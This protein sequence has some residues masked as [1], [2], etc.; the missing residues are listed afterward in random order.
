M[1]GCG[2]PSRVMRARTTCYGGTDLL[3]LE[4]N[5]LITR[6]DRTLNRM[7]HLGPEFSQLQTTATLGGAS[8][9]E[10]ERAFLQER[11]MFLFKTLF[12]LS[13]GF[14][15][16]TSLFVPILEGQP[17]L[18]S[19]ISPGYM[20]H[21]VAV[22]IAYGLWQTCR[23]GPRS[24]RLLRLL[25]SVGL[26]FALYLLK[27]DAYVD[28]DSH[29]LMLGSNAALISR[30]VIVPTTVRRTFWISLA[31][32][33]PDAFLLALM[34][35]KTADGYLVP[36]L[37]ALLW[38]AIAIIMA[39][40]VTKVIYGL[41]KQVRDARKLGQYTLLEMLGAGAMGDVYLASHA[42]MRRRTAIK[43]LRANADGGLARFETEVQLTSQLTHPNTI[44]IYDYGRTAE[45]LFYYVMEYLEGMDLERLMAAAG[46]QSPARVIHILRQVC[47]A[48]EEAHGLGLLHR[49]IK[50]A[51][52]FLCRRRGGPD[53]VK[54]LD[55]GLV[56]QLGASE[57]GGTGQA[58]VVV[59]TPHYLA[60]E[61][62]M[63]PTKV[64]GRADLYSLGA[65]AYALLTGGHVF[66]GQTASEICAH[67][68]NTP[69]E[70]PAARLGR[71]LPDDLCGVVLRCLE[72]RPESRFANA[73]ELRIALELCAD[74]GRWTEED[75]AYWWDQ[76]GVELEKT[77]VRRNPLTLTGTQTVVSNA[78]GR[79]AA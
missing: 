1:A 61:A 9:S 49:D 50:P 11:M 79:V 20:F 59:G 21:L 58:H 34:R 12:L 17:W 31:G 71:E 65:V 45:G 67:H 64:D 14:Y 23:G 24:A 72:K 22:V 43:L 66:Q 27:I 70:P 53:W 40:L 69:P 5:R 48:L 32:V 19:L 55:F 44:A 54:V 26:L 63:D 2:I 74:A 78:L 28:N 30:A 52:L 62:I 15:A 13:A 77:A 75:A 42:M 18:K 29:S 39:C 47:G 68:V 7:M 46:A 37:E 4:G 3:W 33:L 51:N 36:A 57:D 38:S 16:I 25:E 10:D 8:P 56:Q 73:R 6:S 35:S 76:N 60:P 41:R